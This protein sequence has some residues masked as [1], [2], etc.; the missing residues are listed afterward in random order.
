MPSCT[1]RRCDMRT[2]C[3]I[4]TFIVQ[5]GFDDETTMPLCETCYDMYRRLYSTCLE[6]DD[7][8]YAETEEA[9]VEHDEDPTPPDAFMTQTDIDDPL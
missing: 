6:Y 2:D 3:L 4:V 5:H 9:D 7:E 8:A 1:C